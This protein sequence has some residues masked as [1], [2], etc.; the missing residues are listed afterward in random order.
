MFV[1]WNI[2]GVKSVCLYPLTDILLSEGEEDDD[3]S[4]V[5]VAGAE[6][7]RAHHY[8]PEA[9]ICLKYA[10]EELDIP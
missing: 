6:A 2:K 3:D 9:W 4:P 8:L 1:Q 10:R 5:T 7:R